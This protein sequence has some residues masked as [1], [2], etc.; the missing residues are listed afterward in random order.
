MSISEEK[1]CFDVLRH[2]LALTVIYSHG[3]LLGG[4]GSEPFYAF[5]KQQTIAGTLA[6]LGFFGLSGFLVTRSF[7]LREA[8]IPFIASRLLRILP[9]FFFALFLTAFV[10]APLIDGFNRFGQP[11]AFSAALRFCV[12]NACVRIGEW[13]V[14][15]VIDGLPYTES[16]NGALWSL[17]PEVCC[18]CIVLFMGATGVLHQ[19]RFNQLICFVMLLTLHVG[20]VLKP[21]AMFVAPTML[22][23]NGWSPF[24]LAFFTGSAAYLFREELSFSGRRAVFWWLVVLVLIRFGGWALAGPVIFPIALLNLGYAFDRKLSFDFSY[25]TYVL[26]FPIMHLLSAMGLNQYGV[27]IYLAIA[28]LAAILAATASWFLVEKPSL[29]FKK[30]VLFWLRGVG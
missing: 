28:T 14:G 27:A 19:Q 20:W 2:V 25:G 9:G 29:Q 23:L 13:H 18:Y 21:E 1:N 3:H 26:H 15:L 12:G 30:R 22:A 11:W 24:V 6:V 5:S 8:I 10:F 4:F 7:T 17:F 16:I